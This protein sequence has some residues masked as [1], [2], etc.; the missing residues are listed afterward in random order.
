[1]NNPHISTIEKKSQGERERE[2]KRERE[3]MFNL[4]Y[5]IKSYVLR[6]FA[7]VLI[8]LSHT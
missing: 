2:G 8:C 4:K 7:S 6:F 1:V 5:N 3:R